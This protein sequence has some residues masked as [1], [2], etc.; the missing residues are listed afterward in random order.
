M[1]TSSESPSKPVLSLCVIAKNERENLSR[2]LA[3][4]KPYVDEMI[5]VDTGSEDET[6]EIARQYG[7]KVIS[8][9]WCDDFAAARNYSISKASGDWILVLDADEELVILSEYFKE[10]L[11]LHPELLAYSIIRTEVNNTE[12]MAPLHTIRLFRNS[13]E[14][15]YINRFH[16]QLRYQ[17]KPLNA[18]SVGNLESIKILHYGYQEQQLLQKNLNRNIPILEAIRQEEGLSLMLL[19]CLAGMY[20]AT[21]QSEKSQSCYVEAF[22]R[23][24]PNLMDGIPPEDF[25]FIPSLVFTL[26]AQSL[27]QQ[28]YET[29]RLLC[30]RGLEWCPNFPPLNYI[31]GFTV[32]NLGFPLGAIAYFEKCLQFG[33]EGSYYQGEPFELSFTTTEPACALGRA[34]MMM[35]CWQK[36]RESFELALSFDASCTVAKQNLEMILQHHRPLAEG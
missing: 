14:I 10:R 11:A 22:E 9:E 1:E 4:V 31:A 3:S 6:P 5:V 26:A 16:E 35:N 17:S 23:L 24:L 8:F 2:C 33:R 20:G 19:Y 29:A 34:Y 27:Q 12:E 13:L 7:A 25:S 32:L 36:A 28:D 18:L 15:R 21:G 30:Q